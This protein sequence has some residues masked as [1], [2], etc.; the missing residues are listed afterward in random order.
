MSGSKRCLY[1][2]TFTGMSALAMAQGLP[3]GDSGAQVV[4]LEFDDKIADVA[5]EAFDKSEVGG[6]IKLVRGCAVQAMKRMIEDGN[7]KFK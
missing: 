5:Q 2:G 3:K 6:K 4:T 7:S 1:V